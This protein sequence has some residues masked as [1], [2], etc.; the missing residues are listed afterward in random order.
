MN[1]LL[2]AAALLQS[3]LEAAIL[4]FSGRAK[5]ILDLLTPGYRLTS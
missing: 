3:T 2:E 1:A 4:Q 5:D